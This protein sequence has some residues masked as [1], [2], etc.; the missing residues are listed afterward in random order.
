MVVA[1]G[2]RRNARTNTSAC[3]G[4]VTVRRSTMSAVRMT[5]AV[6]VFVRV[7]IRLQHAAGEIDAGEQALRA[8][9]REDF[10]LELRV[11]HRTRV[12][13]D[14]SS[15]NRR[16]ATERHFVLEQMLHAVVVHDEQH[17]VD[18]FAA[19]LEPDA[20]LREHHE[21]RSG[22]AGAVTAAHHALAIFAA[23]DECR[24]FHRRKHDD[25]GGFVPEVL[26]DVLVRRFVQL[27]QHIGRISQPPLLPPRHRR[28]QC[29]R[30]RQDHHTG[31]DQLAHGPVSSSVPCPTRVAS[32]LAHACAR[33]RERVFR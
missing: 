27:V 26:R 10:G 6:R 20:P 31:D 15:R 32:P 8:R 18:G 21:R 17:Q 25:A 11:G 22:P 1:I 16:L 14:R 19:D 29:D 12:T 23:E 3:G 2:A 5:P 7:G 13:P 28:A 24:F 33:L 30:R 4:T 9:V